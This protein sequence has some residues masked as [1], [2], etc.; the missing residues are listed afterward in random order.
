MKIKVQAQH[1]KAGDIVGSG[2]K[3]NC[4]TVNSTGWA[5]NKCLVSLYSGPEGAIRGRNVLWGKY[6][7][8][9]VE[10]ADEQ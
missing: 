1:L 10:R 4:V 6:T 9:N 5:S 8:I 2:E 7:M 3:V